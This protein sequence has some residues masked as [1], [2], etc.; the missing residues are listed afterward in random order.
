[1]NRLPKHIRFDERFDT[2]WKFYWTRQIFFALGNPSFLSDLNHWMALAQAH[3]Q[4]F[5][6]EIIYKKFTHLKPDMKDS[7]DRFVFESYGYLN[8]IAI[9]LDNHAQANY[10]EEWRDSL[11]DFGK[12][13]ITTMYVVTIDDIELIK[14]AFESLITMFYM[15]QYIETA[16]F[17]PNNLPNKKKILDKKGKLIATEVIF[18]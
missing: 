12:H 14:K 3:Y 16:V 4:F 11:Q 1:M 2:D 10:F 18:D 13:A 5:D 15:L 7:S 6:D 17:E 9:A 8:S